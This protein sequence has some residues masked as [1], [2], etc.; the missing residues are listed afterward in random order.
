VGLVNVQSLLSRASPLASPREQLRVLAAQN[1][2][3]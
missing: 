2:M 1:E 3:L